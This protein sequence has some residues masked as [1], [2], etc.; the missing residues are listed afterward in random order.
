MVSSAQATPGD[1]R[2]CPRGRR[3][4]RR[5]LQDEG[6]SKAQEQSYRGFTRTHPVSSP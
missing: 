6:G 2:P 4:E 3:T 5:R 1:T